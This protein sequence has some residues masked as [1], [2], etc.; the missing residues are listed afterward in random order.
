MMEV[1]PARIQE[2][3]VYLPIGGY[4]HRTQEGTEHFSQRIE[5][6]R[7]HLGIHV[8]LGQM[9]SPLLPERCRGHPTPLGQKIVVSPLLPG[10][11]EEEV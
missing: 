10:E 11:Q 2:K 9:L 8:I 6:R 5:G 1:S 7:H 3:Y 4:L